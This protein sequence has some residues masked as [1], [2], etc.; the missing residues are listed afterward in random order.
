MGCRITSA[1][2]HKLKQGKDGRLNHPEKEER[3]A[4]HSD[5]P[6]M[7]KQ[8]TEKDAELKSR[9]LNERHYKGRKDERHYK[10]E[11]TKG[12][13]VRSYRAK[14]EIKRVCQD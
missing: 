6:C 14:G 11:G 7:A 8:G 10:G 4:R 13:K 12:R 3:N 1:S 5:P 2:L 9:A